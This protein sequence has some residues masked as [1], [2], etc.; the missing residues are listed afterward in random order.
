VRL[1]HKRFS[2]REGAQ[3]G[4]RGARPPFIR[5]L[6]VVSVL[7]GALLAATPA[8][9]ARTT[10]RVTPSPS[11]GG[12][13]NLSS[14][15]CS[16]PNFCAVVG[17]A[18][19]NHHPGTMID[20]WDG[21]RWSLTPS[22]S[23]GQ[24]PNLGTLLAV[25]CPS[26]DFCAAVG[27]YAAANLDELTLIEIWNGTSWSIS[28]SPNPSG[29][30]HLLGLS[31]ASPRSCDA[32]GFY[33]HDC[34]SRSG[35]SSVLVEHWDGNRWSVV[36]APQSPCGGDI[37]LEA[38]SCNTPSS[39]TA[40]GHHPHGSEVW[41]LVESWDGSTWSTVPSPNENPTNNN[42]LLGVSCASTASCMAVGWHQ[43]TFG[44]PGLTLIE[45]WN[46]KKWSIVPSPSPGTPGLSD[47]LTGVSCAVSTSTNCVAVGSRQTI[48]TNYANTLIETWD[49][50]AWRGTRS[51]NPRSSDELHG[52]VC[53]GNSSCVAVGSAGS[54][55]DAPHYTLVETRDQIIF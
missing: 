49:G 3:A 22:P 55:T 30:S 31:C 42:E 20:M 34:T 44:G 16:G 13:N 52:V 6:I 43:L 4:I 45:A 35:G 10:W 23:P 12:I 51:P 21:R 33:L 17:D 46:G 15:S 11:R 54:S 29:Y 25:S 7:S 14:V 38:V 48:P 8:V 37:G 5:V 40:V 19:S 50:T 39:C 41:T 1:L 18:F 53:T 28:P 36:L 9:A 26:A 24:E 2:R 27:Y 47:T 32:V